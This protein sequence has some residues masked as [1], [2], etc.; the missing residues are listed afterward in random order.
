MND[1]LTKPL[2]R[3]LIS[4]TLIGGLSL[5]PKQLYFDGHP[6]SIVVGTLKEVKW[7]EVIIDLVRTPKFHYMFFHYLNKRV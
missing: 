5:K 4:E 3:R 7:I 1:P 2:T 6:T